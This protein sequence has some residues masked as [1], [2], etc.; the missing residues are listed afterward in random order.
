[1]KTTIE[2]KNMRFYAYHGVFQEE[3]IYGNDFIVNLRIETDLSKSLETDNIDDTINYGDVYEY[4]KTE[5]EKPSNLLEHLAGRIYKAIKS[6]FP[7]IDFLEV[8]VSKLNPPVNGKVDSSEIIVS[9]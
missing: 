5:M 9:D 1:M 6:A 4:V 8:R 3:R 2:L 7:T